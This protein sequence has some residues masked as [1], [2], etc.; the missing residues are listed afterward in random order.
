MTAD[1]HVIVIGGGIGGLCLAQGLRRSGVAVTVFER[2]EAPDSRR[3]GF[4]L[5]VDPVGARSLRACLPPPLWDAFVASAGARSG[6]SSSARTGRAR[7]CAGS[8]FPTP[9]TRTP[10]A[11]ASATRS[12]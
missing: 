12:T 2:D 3:E 6:T 8:T 11:T 7:A 5:H 9:A 10:A 4:R 1:L